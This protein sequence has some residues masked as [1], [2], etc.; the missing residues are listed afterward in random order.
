MKPT[1]RRRSEAVVNGGLGDA[2]KSQWIREIRRIVEGMMS[3]PQS[4]C[5][6][7]VSALEFS[8]QLSQTDGY[9]ENPTLN[10]GSIGAGE[11]NQ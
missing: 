6:H 5:N 4:G 2:F 9:P 1:D 7:L 8:L 11:P 3:V 10:S